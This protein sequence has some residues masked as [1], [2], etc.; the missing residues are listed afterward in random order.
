MAESILKV[1][2]SREVRVRMDLDADRIETVNLVVVP[3]DNDLV[4][5]DLERHVLGFIER[6]GRAHV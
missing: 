3:R 4:E 2:E 6:I 1:T 5:V